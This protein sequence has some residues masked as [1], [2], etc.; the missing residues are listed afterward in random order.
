V[1]LAS[2]QSIDTKADIQIFDPVFDNHS[3]FVNVESTAL[4]I[5][6]TSD[7]V[8]RIP[9]YAFDHSTHATPTTF[10]SQRGVFEYS[11]LVFRVCDLTYSIVDERVS[12]IDVHSWPFAL[13]V[14]RCAQIYPSSL[15]SLRFAT[16][17][18]ASG[19]NGV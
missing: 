14:R 10:L 1:S 9:H 13:V 16:V 2:V 11:M 15:L 4:S 7:A 18:R 12:V 17:S 19:R 6:L 5:R 3:R 8:S